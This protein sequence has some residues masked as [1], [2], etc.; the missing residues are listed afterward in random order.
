VLTEPEIIERPAQPYVGI[1]A[2]VTMQTIAP[3]LLERHPQVFAWLGKRGIQPAGAPF[4]K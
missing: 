1:R 4:W 2:H 3:V